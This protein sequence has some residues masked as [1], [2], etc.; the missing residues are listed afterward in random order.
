MPACPVLRART[1]FIVSPPT[2]LPYAKLMRYLLSFSTLSPIPR[3]N[4]TLSKS[5]S[6]TTPL[7]LELSD[8]ALLV[9]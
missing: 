4:V 7:Y 2:E 5:P 3:V 8:A 6:T 1:F 9:G